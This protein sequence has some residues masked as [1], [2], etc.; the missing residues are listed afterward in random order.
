M[1]NVCSDVWLLNWA[2]KLLAGNINQRILVGT[3]DLG[4]VGFW[5]KL[6]PRSFSSVKGSVTCKFSLNSGFAETMPE[7]LRK[8]LR[9]G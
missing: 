6:R 8:L 2:V 1:H 4:L 7:D 9:T 3:H 5:A